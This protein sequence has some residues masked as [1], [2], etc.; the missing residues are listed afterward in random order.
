[1]SVTYKQAVASVS[2]R[3]PFWFSAPIPRNP[4]PPPLKLPAAWQASFGMPYENPFNIIFNLALN[5][6]AVSASGE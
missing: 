1:M 6:L 5:R 2:G 3:P 4:P